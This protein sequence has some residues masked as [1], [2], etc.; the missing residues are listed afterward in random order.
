MLLSVAQMGRGD[1]FSVPVL[2]SRSLFSFSVVLGKL[3]VWEKQGEGVQDVE[4]ELSS[5]FRRGG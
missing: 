5:E 1:M 3:A 4:F 2:R